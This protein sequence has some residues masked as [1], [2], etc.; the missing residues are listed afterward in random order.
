VHTTQVLDAVLGDRE[1]VGDR[2]PGPASLPTS[3]VPFFWSSLEIHAPPD[4][5]RR[6]SACAVEQVVVG[7]ELRAAERL[8]VTSQWTP[9]Q[10]L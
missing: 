10:G 4:V 5:Y 8:P 9:T 7:L 2:S 6:S 3:S 1:V